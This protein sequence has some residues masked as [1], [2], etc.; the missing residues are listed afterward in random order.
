MSDPEGI[1]VH[2]LFSEPIMID[3][4]DHFYS[5]KEAAIEDED[6]KLSLEVS[7]FQGPGRYLSI[8]AN[9]K[10]GRFVVASVAADDESV[11]RCTFSAVVSAEEARQVLDYCKAV[12][13]KRPARPAGPLT[14]TPVDLKG[15]KAV[16]PL[17][18]GVTVEPSNEGA[19]NVKGLVREAVEVYLG[20]FSV[21]DTA[22]GREAFA[23]N[24]VVRD[25]MLGA[26]HYAILDRQGT[27]EF[28]ASTAL[29]VN[30]SSS[31]VCS[32]TRLASPSAAER[33]LAFCKGVALQK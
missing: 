32:G 13:V 4:L 28:S 33:V 21:S 8:R 11:V 18:P 29:T 16:L 6:K 12:G 24:D 25:E 2:G 14:P 31:V 20:D 27:T 17:P 15:V 5:S 7:E 23:S 1:R 22:G 9:D 10:G 3:R 19:V 30:A 26:G